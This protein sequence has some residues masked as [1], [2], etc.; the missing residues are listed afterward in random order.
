M[1]PANPSL[2]SIP[3]YS[4]GCELSTVSACCSDPISDASFWNR[5]PLFLQ[6]ALILVLYQTNKKV[7]EININ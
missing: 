7:W 4:S 1:A 5:K 6:I 2:S 3:V